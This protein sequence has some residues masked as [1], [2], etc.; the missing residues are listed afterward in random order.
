M[1]DRSKTSIDLLNEAETSIRL[2]LRWTPLPNY[3]VKAL[4]HASD[5][6]KS[7]KSI[8]NKFQNRKENVNAAS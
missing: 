3:A 8:I 4:F 1:P 2:V 5:Y 6:I 7:A